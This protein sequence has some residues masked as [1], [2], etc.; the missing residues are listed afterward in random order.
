[1]LEHGPGMREFLKRYPQYSLI[2]VAKRVASQYGICAATLRTW[3]SQYKAMRGF[4]PD[5]RGRFTVNFLED[6][7][8]LKL[9]LKIYL[10]QCR[11]ISVDK[12]HLW[13][14]SELLVDLPE[15][16]LSDGSRIR[17]PISR[18]CARH[19][20]KLCGCNYDKVRKTYHNDAHD[21][22]DVILD[23]VMFIAKQKFTSYRE[24]LWLRVMQ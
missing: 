15:G 21:R 7:N 3:I 13:I 9:K 24:Q 6:N 19:W 23:R 12:V 18:S 11:D 5:K 22:H 8:N 2:D 14:N 16:S 10:R 17:Y 4:L 20:M 1:M